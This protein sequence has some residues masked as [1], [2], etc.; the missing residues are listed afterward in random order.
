MFPGRYSV[1]F[2][3]KSVGCYFGDRNPTMLHQ[4]SYQSLET[5]DLS[6]AWMVNLEVPNEA[7]TDIFLVPFF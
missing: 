4:V 2:V 5:I 6:L 7:N 1:V 3:L